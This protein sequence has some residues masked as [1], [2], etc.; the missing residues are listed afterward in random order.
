[1]REL[2]GDEAER[3]GGLFVVGRGEHDGFADR[4]RVGVRTE[5][6]VGG[7][8]AHDRDARW[9]DSDAWLEKSPR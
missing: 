7:A 1:V 4:R 6:S 8:T 3:T 9:V 2:V 5:E